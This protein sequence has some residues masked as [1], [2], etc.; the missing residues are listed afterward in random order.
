VETDISN[1]TR[2]ACTELDACSELDGKRADFLPPIIR[3]QSVL[4]ESGAI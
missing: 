2:L 1:N 4:K 3:I